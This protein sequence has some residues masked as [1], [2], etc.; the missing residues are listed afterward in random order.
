MKMKKMLILVLCTSL[1]GLNIAGCSSKKNQTES[2]KNQSS[3]LDEDEDDTSNITRFDINPVYTEEELE[4]GYASDKAINISLSKDAVKSDSKLVTVNK[5]KATIKA[6]GTYVFTG[7]IE[8]GNI[9]I[10]AGNDDL[11]R[12]ILNNASITSSSTSPI[13]VKNA[14]EVIITLKKDTTNS[15]TDSK[16]YTLENDEEKEP[17]AV[18]YSKD[19]L[20]IN[21]SGKLSI[22]AQY[23]HGIQSK[24]TL[25]IISG[26]LNITS[27]GDAVIGK[28]AVFIKEATLVIDSKEDGIKS[29]K[30]NQDQG[31]IYLD[32]PTI[33]INAV[34]DGIQ[35]ATCL[36][37]KDGT[38]DI[39][40][41]GG[42]ENAEVK[43]SDNGFGGKNPGMDK[44]FNGNMHDKNSSMQPP[45]DNTQDN[46][47]VN[48]QVNSQDNSLDN[49]Q[50]SS[51]NQLETPP[52]LPQGDMSPNQLQNQSQGK[53][54][55]PPQSQS[56]NQDES[57][58]QG[59]SIDKDNTDKVS[60]KGIKAGVDITIKAGDFKQNTSDDA[61]HSNNTFTIDGGVLNLASGDD[62]IHAD[63][64]VTLN[65]GTIN[66]NK[67][68]EGIE[69]KDILVNDG[70]ITIISNDDGFNAAGGSST[71]A[72]GDSNSMQKG[73]D[74][75]CDDSLIINGGI[76]KVNAN[77]DGL[78]SNGTIEMN[79]G[80]V[81]VDGPIN[82]GNGSLDYASEF[83]M[84]A[85]KLIAAGSLGMA[86][87]PTNQSKQYSVNAAL[88]N[89]YQGGTEIVVKDSAG[90]KII[91]YTPSKTFQSFIF[92]SS[93]LKSGETY[94]IYA[95]DTLDSTFSI[96]D[97]ITNVGNNTGNRQQGMGRR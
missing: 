24:D 52:E 88:T 94:S 66:I 63:I 89:S 46:S 96:T 87:G 15:L 32:T 72:S 7:E 76:I 74:E 21:G 16:E 26:D 95:N 43:T 19:D 6:A 84:N 40:T 44:N 92:S 64:T 1:V 34:K 53:P 31:F 79:G 8:D 91:Q 56:N 75:V 77:G 35:A 41:N 13:Y 22:K 59:Q 37:V 48:S 73:M 60:A 47:Q 5:T 78:D 11:V 17:N 4:E 14:K 51:Q 67:S 42:S 9:V 20:T 80:E 36:F 10:D 30:A 90:N 97:I 12:I 23:N 2:S 93:G 29:T 65:A 50:D 57:I 85:G 70:S 28:D 27:V 25:K 33:T 58:S 71:A 38:Y 18:I 86:V 39:T 62:G 82:G 69:G 83:N 49:T 68:Y 61:F 55:A 3:S 45:Q 54:Q 81:Y